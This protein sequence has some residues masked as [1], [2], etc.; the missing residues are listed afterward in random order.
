MIWSFL[1]LEAF[2]FIIRIFF[3]KVTFTTI[4]D[5]NIIVVH[6]ITRYYSFLDI[7]QVRI[8]KRLFHKHKVSPKYM[9]VLSQYK[10]QVAKIEEELKKFTQQPLVGTVVSSQG[11]LL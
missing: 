11:R 9:T 1:T 7:F 10:S 5:Q 8:Y 4:T 6:R 3:G 2:L